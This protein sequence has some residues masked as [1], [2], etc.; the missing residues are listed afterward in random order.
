MR[1]PERR[2]IRGSAAPFRGVGY[3]CV[4]WEANRF[5]GGDRQGQSLVEC[6][7]RLA[8][9]GTRELKQR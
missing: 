6:P 7:D 1:L 8:K 9:G 4:R 2:R 5:F 3:K